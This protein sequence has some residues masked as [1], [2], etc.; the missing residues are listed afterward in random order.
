MEVGEEGGDEEEGEDYSSNSDE[1]YFPPP[2]EDSP[3]S[4]EDSSSSEDDEEEV[5]GMKLFLFLKLQLGHNIL[6]GREDSI[7]H[8]PC[9][10]SRAKDIRR[11]AWFTIS[12]DI[13]QNYCWY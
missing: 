9:I 2:S 3:S 8:S 11:M 5:P 13:I 4:Q 12:N 10:V 6:C 7:R 1:E